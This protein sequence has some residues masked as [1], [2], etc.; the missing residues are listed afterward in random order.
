MI[1]ANDVTLGI[2]LTA[3]IF[4]SRYRRG[5]FS[6][7][8]PAVIVLTVFRDA[9]LWRETVEYLWEHHRLNYPFTTMD[10]F[11][12]PHAI[13][14]LWLVNIIWIIGPVGTIFWAVDQIQDYSKQSKNLKIQ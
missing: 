4:Y 9:T 10:P 1:N 12:R 5:S 3:L 2:I 8:S 6:A 7:A 11:L 13:A 14:N